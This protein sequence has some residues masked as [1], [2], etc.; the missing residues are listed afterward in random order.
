ML[1]DRN[2]RLSFNLH[3][4]SLYRSI[5]L[6][7]ENAISTDL[8]PSTS[9]FYLLLYSYGLKLSV[10]LEVSLGK[11]HTL[12]S[13]GALF[14][15]LLIEQGREAEWD[16]LVD[17]TQHKVTTKITQE[18]MRQ[19]VLKPVLQMTLKSGATFWHSAARSF[20]EL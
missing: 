18:P 16:S 12:T 4:R 1:H 11:S 13:C 14:H 17:T 3:C 9:Y 20:H 5:S 19:G 2:L 15:G 6:W 10:S 7:I 8:L